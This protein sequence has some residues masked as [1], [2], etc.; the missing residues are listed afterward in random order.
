MQKLFQAES[1]F[2]SMIE[3][4]IMEVAQFNYLDFSTGPLSR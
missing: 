2:V 3:R 1:Y 4:S